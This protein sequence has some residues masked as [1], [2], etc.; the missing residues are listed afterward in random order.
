MD[1]S[2]DEEVAEAIA[3]ANN[4]LLEFRRY[5]YDL[6]QDNF[7]SANGNGQSAHSAVARPNIPVQNALNASI[8]FE[9]VTYEF[10]R[11]PKLSVMI[12]DVTTPR[13]IKRQ[14]ADREQRGI[15]NRVFQV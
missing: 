10:L 15:S 3:A 13:R 6:F 12:Y 8:L 2:E 1:L 7:I 5:E 14:A 11:R 9:L 4:R